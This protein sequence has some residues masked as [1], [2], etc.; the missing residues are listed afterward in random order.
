MCHHFSLTCGCSSKVHQ[1]RCALCLNVW[2]GT[3]NCSSNQAPPRSGYYLE[4]ANGFHVVLLLHRCAEIAAM[5]ANDKFVG[6]PE[7]TF[8]QLCE[9]EERAR[10]ELAH[11]KFREQTAMTCHDKTYRDIEGMRSNDYRLK[12][13]SCGLSRR[14]PV[15]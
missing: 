1:P 4:S 11:N 7:L 8:D 15:Y 12:L 14:G 10:S 13:E 9:Q 6:Q 2:C 5:W 3:G